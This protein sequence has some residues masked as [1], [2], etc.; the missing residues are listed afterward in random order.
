MKMKPIRTFVAASVFLSS[1]PVYAVNFDSSYTSIAAKD[2]TTLETDEMMVSVQSCPSFGNILVE[3]T[4]IDLRQ[5][6]TLSRG[7]TDYSLDFRETASVYM[8]V[9]GSKIEWR[10]KSRKPA[11]PVAMIVR[12]NVAENPERDTSYLVVAK[13]TT[14]NIC[15][16]GNVPPQG[17][18]NQKA[19]R[20]AERSAKMPCL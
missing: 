5:S 18:Q 14:D 3:V 4:E 13:I 9:L 10:Y 7:G 17:K 2:C 16:V 11:S 8:N 19:R 12:L 6:I 1:L 20:M 15:V